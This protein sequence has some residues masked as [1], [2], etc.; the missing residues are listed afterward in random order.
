MPITDE[1]NHSY[2]VR[3]NRYLSPLCLA[4]ALEAL[5][6]CTWLA[7]I[8]ADPKNAVW[9]GFSAI[10]L[11]IMA[12]AAGLAVLFTI[13]GLLLRR[14]GKI[15]LSIESRAQRYARAGVLPAF[16]AGLALLVLTLLPDYRLGAYGS[17][18]ARIRPLVAW[19]TIFCLQLCIVASLWNGQGNFKHRL[20]GLVT[21]KGALRNVALATAVFLAIW[22]FVGL[23]GIGNDPHDTLWNL[24]EA[25]V[26]GLQMLA[27]W[28]LAFLYLLFVRRFPRWQ[29][30]ANW[31]IVVLVWAG[32]VVMW[33]NQPF[34][35]DFFV[36]PKTPPA[37]QFYP[38]S[39]AQAYDLSSQY[40]LL[41]GGYNHRYVDKPVL[42]AMF[43]AYHL[44]AGQDYDRIIFLQT[45]VLAT[46]PAILFLIGAN[47]GSPA[48]GIIGAVLF[49]SQEANRIAG[50][51]LIQTSS[52]RLL[53]SELPTALLLALFTLLFLR[54][55]QRPDRRK[56][57]IFAAGCFLGLAALTRHNPWLL[58]P[59]GFVL[60]IVA[61]WKQWK[62]MLL[63]GVLFGLGLAA[64]VGPWMAHS[65][66]MYGTP[67]YFMIPGEGVVVQTRYIPEIERSVPTPTLPPGQEESLLPTP[68]LPLATA[69]AAPQPVA[70]V[71]PAAPSPWE[72][73]GVVAFLMVR[74]YFHNLITSAM[75]FPLR[76]V[77]DDLSHTITATDSV[78]QSDWVGAL[79]PTSAAGLVFILLTCAFGVGLAWARARLA[80][81]MPLVYFASYCGAVSVALTSGGRYVVPFSWVVWLY[82]GVGL[83]YLTNLGLT[84]AGAQPEKPPA[85]PELPGQSS[86]L[87][88]VAVTILILVSLLASWND[89]VIRVLQGPISGG[90]TPRAWLG[91]AE[92]QADQ[93]EALL[94]QPGA[95]LVEAK[96]IYPQYTSREME[97]EGVLVHTREFSFILMTPDGEYQ[98]SLPLEQAP[99]DWVDGGLV[100]VL[101]CQSGNFID[102]DAVA[103]TRQD[104]TFVYTRQPNIPLPCTP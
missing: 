11:L 29:S 54:W 41:G 14:D 24:V 55:L 5:G 64:G 33:W 100:Q 77:F 21:Q 93:V 40:A 1:T 67:F 63:A 32:A 44:L 39:D 19:G 91:G 96:A 23:T 48:G 6:A 7:L 20:S 70:T 15:S 16:L 43:T 28:L 47:L 104:D 69:A 74:H 102:A 12:T 34:T 26:L 78:W 73:Y 66:Q 49:I 81:M 38:T 9:M 89:Q 31:V 98:V 45:L 35:G 84:L 85:A 80:G 90:N 86:R 82:A 83:A 25:P 71:E 68:E 4:T 27:A 3:M 87:S 103:F 95:T 75:V 59:V 10:R 17:S 46:L 30:T 60:I 37:F 2:P 36:T 101:G 61:L 99:K 42:T 57:F 72:H 92:R 58:V 97:V 76:G 51:R 8:P 18:F 13:T 79:T 88:W 94:R 22:A 62:R 56:G 50:S 52:S 53:L 65:V